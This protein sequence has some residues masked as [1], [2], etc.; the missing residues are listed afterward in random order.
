M[1]LV[2]KLLTFPV[3]VPV[4]GIKGLVMKLHET[5]E[6]QYYNAEAVRAELV[7]LG[8]RLDNGEISE[9]VFE[10]LEE[11]LLDRLDEIE[12]Y[13]KAKAEGAQ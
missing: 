4:A 2:S 8:D 7:V 3:S 1:G 6:A 10:E 11:Q 9:E 12:A 13:Q 5:A